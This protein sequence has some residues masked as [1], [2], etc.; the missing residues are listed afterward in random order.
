MLFS[1]ILIL[2]F[3][4]LFILHIYQLNR[5]IYRSTDEEYELSSNTDVYYSFNRV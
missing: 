1:I 4:I 3:L 5:R 2:M